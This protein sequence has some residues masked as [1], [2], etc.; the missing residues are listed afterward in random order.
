MK[1]FKKNFTINLLQMIDRKTMQAPA[2]NTGISV[3]STSIIVQ[4]N[5]VLAFYPRMR[6]V[7][8]LFPLIAVPTFSSSAIATSDE[9]EFSVVPIL[10][11]IAWDLAHSINSICN[12]SNN[13]RVAV[14][15]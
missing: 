9:C 11:F 2:V 7:L 10:I 8:S 12:E 15:A 4:L 14:Y 1:I 3:T 6:P 5:I 13:L